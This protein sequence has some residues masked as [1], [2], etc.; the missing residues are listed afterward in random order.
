MQSLSYGMSAEKKH[1][2][3]QNNNKIA[4]QYYLIMYN[5]QKQIA[6]CVLANPILS[7]NMKDNLI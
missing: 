4:E 1:N 5:A 3:A 7:V 2:V 6:Q